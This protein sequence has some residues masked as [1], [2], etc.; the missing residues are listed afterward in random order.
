MSSEKPKIIHY[1]EPDRRG[2][3]QKKK[4]E[5]EFIESERKQA[6]RHGLIL[7][8]RRDVGGL[9]VCYTERPLFVSP[10]EPERKNLRFEDYV[11]RR[12]GW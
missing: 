9:I 3:E 8:T 12:L 2:P 7:K 6:E 4:D 1:V 10:P 5:E 11:R